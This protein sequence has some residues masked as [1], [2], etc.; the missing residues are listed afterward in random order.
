MQEHTGMTSY[1]SCHH[2]DENKYDNDGFA[3]GR[4]E[5][6]LVARRGEGLTA[7]A[8]ASSRCNTWARAAGL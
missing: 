4:H 6:D 2:C 7:R 1:N 3:A 8:L 5:R